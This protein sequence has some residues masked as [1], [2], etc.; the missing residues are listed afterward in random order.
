MAPLPDDARRIAEL[1]AVAGRDL[2]PGELVALP[3]DEPHA[4]ASRA[5]QTGLLDA[6]D[7]RLGYR[8]AL[9]SQAVYADLPGPH[10]AQLHEAIATVL[11]ERDDPARGR[12][13]AEAARHLR[14]AGRDDR[15]VEQLARAAGHARAVGAI[16]EA[17]AFLAEALELRPDDADLL[18]A[19]S[20]AE[21]WRG[22]RTDAE[23]RFEQAL[24]VLECERD[25][26]ACATAWLHLER[27][28][29]G[30]ICYPRGVLRTST[31]VLQIL[32]DAGLEARAIR[33][34]ALSARAWAEAI[35][36]DADESER[37]L[38]HIHELAG[39]ELDDTL[40]RFDIGHARQLAYIRGEQFR[41]AYGPSIAAGH[42]AARAGRPDLSAGVWINAAAAAMA[43][44]EHDRAE[45]FIDRS[46]AALEGIGTFALELLTWS[47]RAHLYLR[48]GRL[49]DALAAAERSEEL[50]DRLGSPEYA[51]LAACDSGLVAL[52]RGEHERAVERLARALDGDGPIS[53][54][55]ARLARAEALAALQRC[56]EADAEIR[57]T[58]LEPVGPADFPDTLVARLTRVQGLVAAA[59]GDRA[60]AQRRL[61]ESA[62]AWRRIA[63][64]GRGDRLNAVF[65]DF[66]RPAIG[67]VEPALELE[68]VQAELAEMHAPVQ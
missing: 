61:Q 41:E 28:Y 50:A 62:D 25:P 21:A 16:D 1:T 34:E 40:L 32:D 64:G 43:A 22:R 45:E 57:A 6:A 5:V 2:D 42:E 19:A 48:T 55:L 66:G 44:G 56:D 65:A 68:R 15:A 30:P 46:L 20:D 33:M 11:I 63:D 67:V 49:D 9:L 52:A 3:V 23:A 18:L 58:A 53:R 8:H 36:G 31:R 12:R 27:G 26:L 7:G 47:A 35:A 60:L 24:A 10:R 29:H 54:P 13:A 39:G 4:A 59:R 38:A 17:A 37:L 14:L 51:V